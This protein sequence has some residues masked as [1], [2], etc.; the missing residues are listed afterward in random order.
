MYAIRSYY[1]N[2]L[3][4]NAQVSPSPAIVIPDNTIQNGPDGVALY[5]GNDT[6]FPFGTT[7]VAA[8][9]VDAL[10]Y[11]GNSTQP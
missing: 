4:G 3:I 5:L 7:A 10:A 6:D 1:G 2:L 8:N 11:T 9:L